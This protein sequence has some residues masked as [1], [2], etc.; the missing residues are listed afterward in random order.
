MLQLLPHKFPCVDLFDAEHGLIQRANKEGH[1]LLQC[2]IINHPDQDEN[3][4]HLPAGCD[5]FKR[6]ALKP[7]P[8]HI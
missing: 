3:H 2:L 1:K 4:R 5:V 6:P 8:G 7:P